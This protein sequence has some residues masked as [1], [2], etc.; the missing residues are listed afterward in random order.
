MIN[1]L[2]PEVSYKNIFLYTFLFLLIAGAIGVTLYFLVFRKKSCKADKDCKSGQTCVS[3]KCQVA[4]PSSDCKSNNDCKLG[5]TCFSGKCQQFVPPT[6]SSGGCTIDKDCGLGKACVGGQCQPV[7]PPSS[8]GCNAD[9][10][11]GSGKACVGGQCQPVSKKNTGDHCANDSECASNA[12]G[13][14][15]GDPYTQCCAGHTFTNL[16]N[17]KTDICSLDKDQICYNNDNCTSCH[18]DMSKIKC[19]DPIPGQ[20]C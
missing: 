4:P 5:Q 2:A 16:I 7:V 6:P 1:E 10:D 9:K 13:F 18:C 3:G 8:G 12:C 14:V 17:G 15:T 20:T 19:A 11:C